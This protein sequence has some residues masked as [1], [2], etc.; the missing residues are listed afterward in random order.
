MTCRSFCERCPAEAREHWWR[1]KIIYF[2]TETLCNEN[3]KEWAISQQ[4]QPPGFPINELTSLP[5]SLEGTS[6]QQHRDL[7]SCTLLKS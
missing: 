5:L 7:L 4:H 3:G 2:T 1:R 6:V